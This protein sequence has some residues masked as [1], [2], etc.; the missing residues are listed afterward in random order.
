MF[1]WNRS[2]KNYLDEFNALDV[3]MG[4]KN[5]EE[6]KKVDLKIDTD[7]RKLAQII[8]EDKPLVN[9]LLIVISVMYVSLFLSGIT[10]IAVN[11][12]E[13]ATENL[14]LLVGGGGS[15]GLIMII[16]GLKSVWR[17]KSEMILLEMAAKEWPSED[18]IRLAKMIYY[19][20]K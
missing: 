11:P 7:N 6:P 1:N 18:V 19:S 2:L 17:S 14:A 9:T 5:N 8:N 3:R 13:M 20:K 4:K 16:Q 12:M 15:T 10:L